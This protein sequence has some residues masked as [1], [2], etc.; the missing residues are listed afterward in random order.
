MK[1][2]PD[3]ENEFHSKTLY[4]DERINQVNLLDRDDSNIHEAIKRSINFYLENVEYAD[5]GCVNLFE[6][7]L[8]SCDSIF[9]VRVTTDGD[10]GWIEL[11]DNAGNILELGRT[12]ME[13]IGFVEDINILRNYV[14]TYSFPD[15][16]DMSKSKWDSPL[17]WTL[18]YVIDT[19]S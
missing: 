19:T 4:I 2:N 17:P 7:S 3:N 11:F 16:M 18:D 15:C 6:I 13:L 1:Q 12:Y 8:K 5:V 14:T 9:M 10:D